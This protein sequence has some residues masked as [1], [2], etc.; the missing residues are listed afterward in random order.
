MQAL[1]I[2]FLFFELFLAPLIDD[3]V[4]KITNKTSSEES[5]LPTSTHQSNPR[6]TL[7]MPNYLYTY[8]HVLNLKLT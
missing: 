2:T 1:V 8:I 6:T 7:G 4:Y 5:K 3:F